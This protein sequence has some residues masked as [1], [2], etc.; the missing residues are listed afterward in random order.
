MS[1]G[2][3]AV[4]YLRDVQQKLEVAAEYAS[5]HAE[6]EQERYR[7]YQNLRSADKHFEV[8]QQVLVLV[9]IPD[10]TDSKLFSKCKGPATVVAVRSPYSYEVNLDGN[11]RHYHANHLRIITCELSL[12]C[13]IH[14]R[15]WGSPRV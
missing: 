6:V 1:F 14:Q 12:F 7:K 3:S 11:V 15:V 4:E 5:S 10:T 8:G 13:T 9:L 2:K